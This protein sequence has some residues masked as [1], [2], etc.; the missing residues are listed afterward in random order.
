MLSYDHC[1]VFDGGQTCEGGGY[2][3]VDAVRGTFED[4]VYDP[5]GSTSPVHT[6]H[7][8]TPE[9]IE[10]VKAMAADPRRRMYGVHVTNHGLIHLKDEFKR[11][12]EACNCVRIDTVT[13]NFF[14]SDD[15]LPELADWNIWKPPFSRKKVPAGYY[16]NAT[17]YTRIWKQYWQVKHPDPTWWEKLFIQYGPKHNPN[18]RFDRFCNTILEVTCVTW[19]FREAC[20]YETRFH[21]RVI[22]LPYLDPHDKRWG[23][24]KEPFA[25]YQLAAKQLCEQV[26]RRLKACPPHP[27][28]VQNRGEILKKTREEAERRRAEAQAM[29]ANSSLNVPAGTRAPLVDAGGCPVKSGADIGAALSAKPDLV[30]MKLKLPRRS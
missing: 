27:I 2:R 26:L 13:P 28:A 5:N 23:Y 15:Q 22:S 20:D 30:T 11:I 7:Q 21:V 12:A 1:V 18:W 16:P 24:L 19:Y 10:I 3:L 14:A 17:G 9:Q 25:K 6:T 29:R 4:D 8:L